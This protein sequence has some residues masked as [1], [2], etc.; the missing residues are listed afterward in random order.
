M[1]ETK[2][3]TKPAKASGKA[4]E[5]FTAD[6]IAAMRDRARELKGTARQAASRAAKAADDEN[7]VLAKIAE[8]QEPD[9]DIAQRIHAI[10]KSIAPDIA[11]KTWYGMPAYYQDGNMI[12]FFK[13]RYKFK[14]RYAT[15]GF[16]DKAHL[17]EG[18]MWPSEYALVK[19]TAADEAKIEA[20]VKRAVS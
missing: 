16:G 4:Y 17:D 1:N 8:M 11:P 18:S 2:K 20:L 10:V 13:S 5:G 19:L 9:R 6:E 12:C 7:E 3:S 15:L 14:V